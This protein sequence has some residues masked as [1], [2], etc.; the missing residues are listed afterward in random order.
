VNEKIYVYV[1]IAL[2]ATFYV[3]CGGE[4]NKGINCRFAINENFQQVCMDS[5][6]TCRLDVSIQNVGTQSV[7][8]PLHY[9]AFDA[10]QK[11]IGYADL[12]V[13]K[14]MPGASTTLHSDILAAGDNKPLIDC[15]MVSSVES[16]SVPSCP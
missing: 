9:D 2:I 12:Q 3:G 14:L 11:K 16:I 6:C 13:P 15:G 7:S 1:M 10:N 8:G 4:T 5:K